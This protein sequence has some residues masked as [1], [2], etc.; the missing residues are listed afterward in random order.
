MAQIGTGT[1]ILTAANTYAGGTTISAGTLQIGDGGATGR[2]GTGPV[3]DDA[4][5]VF[6]RSGA[7]AVPRRQSPEPDL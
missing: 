1:T 6:N 7:V 3:L 2:I 4:A 5:L